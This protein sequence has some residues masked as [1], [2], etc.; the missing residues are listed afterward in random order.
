MTFLPIDGYGSIFSTVGNSSDQSSFLLK[1]EGDGSSLVRFTSTGKYST[2]QTGGS[3]GT[4]TDRTTQS[5]S[6]VLK[7]IAKIQQGQQY[8]NGQETVINRLAVG[9]GFPRAVGGQVFTETEGTVVY[10]G[11]NPASF[12]M[13][14]GSNSISSSLN[15][16]GAD[17]NFR[18]QTIPANSVLFAELSTY[19]RAG[20]NALTVDR[21]Q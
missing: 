12:F 13:F 3:D 14:G 2:S 15:N 16:P 11:M 17:D 9:Y 7:G 1:Y 10:R 4:R 6:S 5:F 20:G 19:V 21:K 8:P 18:T